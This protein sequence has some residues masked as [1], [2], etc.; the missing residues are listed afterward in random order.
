V[1]SWIAEGT[2]PIYFGFGSTPIASP[3]ETVAVIGM[4]CAR[5]GERAL[6]CSGPNDFTDVPRFDHVKLAVQVSHSVIFPACRAVAH[7]G[8]AGVTAA[9][10]RAGVPTLIL[11]FWLDQPM[12]ADGVTRLKV[13][14][15]RAFLESTLDSLVAD[16]RSILT[17]QCAARAREVAP[18]M[19]KSAESVT[20]A[21]DLLEDAARAGL[22]PT[23]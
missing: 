7:H 4:A 8:G 18:Q 12:W 11:W 9:G 3:A 6:I 20:R 10:L 16:L 21:A 13:G 14:A 19:T 5:L 2:P 15:G 17:P 1:L 23:R 22:S